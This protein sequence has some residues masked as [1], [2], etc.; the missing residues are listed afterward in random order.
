MTLCECATVYPDT[1]T[2]VHGRPEC[3][4]CGGR[5]VVATRVTRAQWDAMFAAGWAVDAGGEMR[6]GRYGRGR[7][8]TALALTESDARAKG[9]GR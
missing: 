8:E 7:V 4:A 9:A 2:R 3:Q 6:H 5:G 1:A